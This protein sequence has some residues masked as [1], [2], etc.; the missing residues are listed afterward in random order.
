MHKKFNLQEDLGGKTNNKCVS[1]IQSTLL[2]IV[3]IWCSSQ[4]T[5]MSILLGIANSYR[6]FFKKKRSNWIHDLVDHTMK[7]LDVI[8][9]L[10]LEWHLLH[11]LASYI[12]WM[13]KS[14]DNFLNGKWMLIVYAIQFFFW[15]QNL[16]SVVY[17]GGI[18]HITLRSLV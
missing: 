2:F 7:N 6:F 14:N 4:M 11:S 17:S 16:C 13:N 15:I 18:Y 10:V 1:F 3:V 8:M 12:L 5:I 9:A